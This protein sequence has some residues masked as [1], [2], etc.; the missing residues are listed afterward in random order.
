LLFM[1]AADLAIE[2]NNVRSPLVAIVVGASISGLI[3]LALLARADLRNALN[4][5]EFA[6]AGAPRLDGT[7]DYPNTAAMA[8]EA[9]ALLAVSLIAIETRRAVAVLWAICIVV[10]VTA[11]ILTLSRGATVGAAIGMVAV[12]TLAL[13]GGRRRI[14]F[15]IFGA[16]AALVVVT[17]LIEITVAPIARLFTD[18]EAGLY[19]ATYQAPATATLNNGIAVA[20]VQVTN[21]GTLTW[22]GDTSDGDYTLGYHW[23]VPDT[24]EIVADGT[25]FVPLGTVAPGQTTTVT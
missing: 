20:E 7:Y 3:G 10:M 16:A 22:N 14:G 4:V 13:I 12:G 5:H 15:S 21:T 25:D 2:R 6:A 1:A 18:A 17:L 19:N 11:M 8:W 24:G 23:L 9:A